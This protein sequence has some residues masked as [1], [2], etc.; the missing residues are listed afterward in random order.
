MGLKKSERATK[1]R[2]DQRAAAE[3]RIADRRSGDESI[4]KTEDRFRDVVEISS[5]WFWELDADLQFIY[6]SD[7]GYTII[8]LNHYRLMSVELGA[9]LAMY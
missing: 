7:K 8:K 5:D 1:G 9:C 2:A 4:R 6:M 3:R